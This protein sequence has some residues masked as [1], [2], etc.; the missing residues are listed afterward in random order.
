MRY[1]H[2]VLLSIS[3]LCAAQAVA[4]Q[5]EFSNDEIAIYRDFLLH[6]PERL[7]DLI[8]MEPATRDFSQ[9]L[10]TGDPSLASFN[11]VIPT[12]SGRKLPEEIVL[13][14]DEEA[15]TRRLADA[16]RLVP[17]SER[18][19]GTRPDGYTSTHLRLSEIAFD[20]DHRLAVLIFDAEC[21]C[22]G[23]ESGIALYKHTE[24]GWRLQKPLLSHWIG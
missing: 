21:H 5:A 13:L 1:I 11:L 22:K 4:Q 18:G 12:Q 16:G 20:Q 10:K 8:G 14:A 6:Y 23:G 19:P 24:N 2:L 3:S 9:M 17:I 7:G 15:V